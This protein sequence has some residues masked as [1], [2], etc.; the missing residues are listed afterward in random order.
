MAGRG[1]G[2]KI[3]AAALCQHGRRRKLCGECGD[4]KSSRTAGRFCALLRRQSRLHADNCRNIHFASGFCWT[5]GCGWRAARWFVS[6]SNRVL[7]NMRIGLSDLN[8]PPFINA[9]YV[10]QP[11]CTR[12]ISYKNGSLSYL[13]LRRGL[14]VCWL[15]VQTQSENQSSCK[16]VKKHN[17][18]SIIRSLDNNDKNN[19]NNN[20]AAAQYV[21]NI[22]MYEKK[23]RR[24]NSTHRHQT[25]K[26]KFSPILR[27]CEACQA[28]NNKTRQ[29]K[30]IHS[31]SARMRTSSPN[32]WPLCSGM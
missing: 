20:C 4:G 30:Q 29:S 8:T 16:Q 19:S 25:T 9:Q 1:A 22:T 21:D 31:K 24:S 6:R 12:E 11:D 15:Q 10:Q 2:E 7:Q 3:A 18:Q 28:A 13:M 32:K 26:H 14:L 17:F 23:R 5:R 27:F